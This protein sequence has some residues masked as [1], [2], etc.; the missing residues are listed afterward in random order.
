LINPRRIDNN[1]YAKTKI[2][3]DNIKG[4]KQYEE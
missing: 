4:D 2:I 3:I 1:I